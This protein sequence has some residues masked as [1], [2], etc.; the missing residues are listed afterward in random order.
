MPLVPCA[1]ILNNLVEFSL[2]ISC[3]ICFVTFKYQYLSTVRCGFFCLFVLG[4]FCY[5]QKLRE[6]VIQA[7]SLL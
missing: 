4:V 6:T 1:W 7:N 2:Y 5:V 3:I